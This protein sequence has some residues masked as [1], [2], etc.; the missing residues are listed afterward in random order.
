[1]REMPRIE[2]GV[3]HDRFKASCIQANK[4]ER[5]SL[6]CDVAD[7]KTQRKTGVFTVSVR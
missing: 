2:A 5:L 1:M 4:T 3:S 6:D 7:S